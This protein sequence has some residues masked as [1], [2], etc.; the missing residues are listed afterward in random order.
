MIVRE[1]EG[2]ETPLP[3]KA[4]ERAW[5]KTRHVTI[6][7]HLGPAAMFSLV[8]ERTHRFFWGLSVA[9]MFV[10]TTVDALLGPRIIFSRGVGLR[11]CSYPS[12]LARLTSGSA[13]ASG[14]TWLLAATKA[15]IRD[16]AGAFRVGREQNPKERP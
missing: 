1:P 14:S 8:T 9:I 4:A 13:K 10:I 12:K 15:A 2:I 11:V 16:K 3:G 6:E 7:H 5:S